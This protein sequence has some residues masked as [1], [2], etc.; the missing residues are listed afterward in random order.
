MNWIG[1]VTFTTGVFALGT[2]V[3][4]GLASLP[5]VGGRLNWCQWMFVQSGLGHVCLAFAIAHN[6]V[7]GL[8]YTLGKPL[9]EN[10]KG[11]E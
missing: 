2:M 4:L 8:P 10:L 5:S 11:K 7:Q 1:E 6:I 3:L 9:K